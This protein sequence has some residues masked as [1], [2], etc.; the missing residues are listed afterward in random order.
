MDATTS[1][2]PCFQAGDHRANEQ[3]GLLTMHTIWMREHNR[4]AVDLLALNPHWDTDTVY[5]EARKIV[6]AL[7]QHITYQHWLPK[8]SD[9]LA[10]DCSNNIQ[11]KIV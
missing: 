11:A 8:V 4:I 3:L 9:T 6:G 1:H 10:W 7:V 2:V 5:H